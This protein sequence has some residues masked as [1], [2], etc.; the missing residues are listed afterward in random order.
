ME[1][2]CVKTK[3]KEGSLEGVRKWLQTLKDNESEVLK[4]LVNEGMLVESVFLDKQ[5]DDYYLIYYMK[6][7]DIAHAREVGRNS[8]SAIDLYHKDCI[9]KFCEGRIELEQLLDLNNFTK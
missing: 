5:G 8:T 7:K 6:A 1:T 9:K 4:S 2:I 3:L